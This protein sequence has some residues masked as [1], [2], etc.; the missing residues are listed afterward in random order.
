LAGKD[1]TGQKLLASLE[2]GK[3]FHDIFGSPPAKF[4]PTDHLA[5]TVFQVQQI[6]KGRWKVLREGVM[7]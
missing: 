4:S 1:L 5:S 3:E 6:Q 7:F 2:S